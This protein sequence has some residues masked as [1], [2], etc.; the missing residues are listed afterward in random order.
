MNF[1]EAVM[2]VASANPDAFSAIVEHAR[3][4]T[5]NDAEVADL[6]RA[7]AHSGTI[8]SWEG[9]RARATDVASTGGPASLTT[10]LCPIYLV[11]L[12]ATV[13][14]LGVPGRPAGGIDVLA[15]LPGFRYELTPEATRRVL[16]E[17]N[18][19]HLLAGTTFAPADA[20]LFKYRR[21]HGAVALPQL[22]MASLLAKKLC[23]GVARAGM[24]VRVGA[25]ANF[26][27]SWDVARAHVQQFI[28]VA[29]LVGIELVCFLTDGGGPYQPY[30][31][32]GEAIVA[33]R[34]ALEGEADHWLDQHVE[35]C[36]AMA[37]ATAGRSDRKPKHTEIRAVVAT[38]LRAQ[39]ANLVD[40]YERAD[41]VTRAHT[42]RVTADAAGFLRVNLDSIRTVIVDLQRH[43][44]GGHAFPDPAG[45][46]LCYRT[47]SF[48]ERGAVIATARGFSAPE[49]AR[50]LDAAFSIELQPVAVPG[51]EQVIDGGV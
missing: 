40:L 43:D 14:K 16:E 15:Q 2:S 4:R 18:Y 20:A 10:L 27:Y 51:F 24:D 9:E 26:G 41:A 45:V 34:N 6:A 35:A 47:G 23:V 29:K 13:V 37:A 1:Q 25:G 39:G 30:V 5:L 32:R 12:G 50:R 22:A 21:E 3:A 49:T 8:M 48:V 11:A 28:R 42:Y 7:L 38:H 36:F 31:G 19:V 17:A 33:L 44:A 46:R